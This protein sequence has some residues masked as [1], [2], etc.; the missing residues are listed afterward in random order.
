MAWFGV[1]PALYTNPKRK[2]MAICARATT[3]LFA[4]AVPSA[5]VTTF[6]AFS[7]ATIAN[8]TTMMLVDTSSCGRRPTRSVISAPNTAPTNCTTFC[9]PC[10]SSR[11]LLFRMPAPAS[12]CG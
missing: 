1:Q 10:S 6:V 11:V 7:A 12:I 3:L 5:S 4:T 8:S 9:S 2:I